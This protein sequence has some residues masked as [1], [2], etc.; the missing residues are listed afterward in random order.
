MQL[1]PPEFAAASPLR[2]APRAHLREPH[3]HSADLQYHLQV[4]VED[5]APVEMTDPVEKD[6]SWHFKGSPAFLVRPLKR[7]L[8]TGNRDRDGL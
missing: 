5:G 8:A 4:F 3:P 1:L 7:F 2:M 6:P